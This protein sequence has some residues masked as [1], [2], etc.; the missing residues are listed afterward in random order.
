MKSFSKIGPILLALLLG[1]GAPMGGPHPQESPDMSKPGGIS[2]P[3]PPTP[4]KDGSRIR[5]LRQRLTTA[6]GFQ[7]TD[8]RYGYFDKQLNEYCW[9]TL[10]SSGQ[11][12]CMP[13]V[14]ATASGFVDAGCT[15]PAAYYNPSCGVRTYATQYIQPPA[16][17]CFGSRQ[18]V[19]KIGARVDKFYVGSPGSCG[20][21]TPPS[22][23]QIFAT[24]QV[25]DE[26]L[27]LM[28]VTV[29]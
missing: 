24:T 28:T 3:P 17:S 19:F 18:R 23:D 12:R 1:C 10:D 15:I 21:G 20:L 7:R 16:N 6:D 13:S 4:D 26:D 8:D 9:P 5:V 14:A 22:G 29:Y 2:D 25:P 11:T 27:A